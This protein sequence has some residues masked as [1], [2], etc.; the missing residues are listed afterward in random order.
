MHHSVTAYSSGELQFTDFRMGEARPA[1]F[2]TVQ[3]HSRENLTA[4]AGH[5]HCS[6]IATGTASQVDIFSPPTPSPLP[7]FQHPEQST[8]PFPQKVSWW[9]SY[10]PYFTDSSES[11]WLNCLVTVAWERRSCFTIEGLPAVELHYKQTSVSEEFSG[12]LRHCGEYIRPQD[13]ANKNSNLAMT[14]S[15]ILC[16]RLKASCASSTWRVPSRLISAEVWSIIRLSYWGGG[17]T[18]RETLEWQWRA[19]RCGAYTNIPA[20][21]TANGCY[22]L[23]ELSSTES[24]VGFRECRFVCY[25]LSYRELFHRSRAKFIE[26]EQPAKLQN[27]EFNATSFI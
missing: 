13:I 17:L 16:P 21:R 22:H 1:V 12:T 3:A 23:H 11:C 15:L 10:Y 19:E 4:L 24:H 5:P 6:L 25:N 2:R 20:Q 8:N 26:W 14:W 27:D 7:L 18:G 9:K